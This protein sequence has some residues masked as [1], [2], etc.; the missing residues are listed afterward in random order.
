MTNIDTVTVH[1]EY[2]SVFAWWVK[3]DYERSESNNFKMAG[4]RFNP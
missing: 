2:R 3:A 4:L 1:D